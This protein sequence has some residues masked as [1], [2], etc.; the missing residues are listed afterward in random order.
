MINDERADYATKDLMKR[1]DRNRSYYVVLLFYAAV[2][3]AFEQ[4]LVSPLISTV[5]TYGWKVLALLGM[6]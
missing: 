2:L 6:C 1:I 4:N 5:E 3:G